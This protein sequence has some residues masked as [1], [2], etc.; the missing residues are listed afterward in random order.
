M[1]PVTRTSDD[2]AN[3][4]QAMLDDTTQTAW[5][6]EYEA[7]SDFLLDDIWPGDVLHM[8]VASRGCTADVVVREVQVESLD[9]ANQRSRYAIAFANEAAEPVAIKTKPVTV[10]QSEKVVMRD[11]A[12]FA[13]AGLQQAEVTNITSTQVTID[14]GCD[15]IVGGGFE[16][17]W[18]DSGWGPQID[19]NLAGRFN[20]CVITVPRLT[21][22]MSYWIRQYDATNRY[23]GPAT[24]LHVDYP[25]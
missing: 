21:R 9:P 16:V 15:P 18:S 5:S 11:P 20:T 6:G 14:A 17:R 10:L 23:S 3:A 4:V 25:L 2:C 13:L 7:W 22:V 1:L 19:R 12:V 8:N 24:L